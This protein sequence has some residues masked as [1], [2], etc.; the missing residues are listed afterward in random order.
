MTDFD[1]LD[2]SDVIVI[3]DESGVSVSVLAGA[4]D[5]T[6]DF[7][8]LHDVFFKGLVLSDCAWVFFAPSSLCSA[9]GHL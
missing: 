4:G 3:E 9:L 6:V 1:I 7:P 5:A 2:C 8:M